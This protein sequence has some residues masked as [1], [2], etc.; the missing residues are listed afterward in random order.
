MDIFTLLMIA[1]GLSM[2]NFAVSLASGCNPNIKI[3]DISKAALLFVAAHLVMFSLGWF[4]VSVIAERFDA[5]DH[6]ISFGLL[7]FIGLRMIKEAAAKK[8]Q[9]ECVNITET[10]SRLLLIALAT[11]MDALAVGISL[12]LA[13]VHFV[14]SVAAISFFVLITTFFGFKIGGK[15][16]DKL[17]IKAEIFGGIVLIGIALKILL[18]AMM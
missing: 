15:L 16:G 2:D 13:G 4:G 3:K 10:F 12:S 8:G 5:Y 9:Q 18:D 7:V 11:S 6:W 14:L 1:A 17:G